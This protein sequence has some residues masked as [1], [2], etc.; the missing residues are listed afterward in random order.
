MIGWSNKIPK[1][2]WNNFII[3]TTARIY[4]ADLRTYQHPFENYILIM[5]NVRKYLIEKQVFKQN[6]Y[7]SLSLYMPALL[8]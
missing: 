2:P 3:N 6:I 8:L 1:W 5:N 4:K 7:K